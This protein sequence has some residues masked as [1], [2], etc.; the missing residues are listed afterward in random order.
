MS[1][2]AQKTGTITAIRKKNSSVDISAS[3]K[4][5]TRYSVYC[6]TTTEALHMMIPHEHETNTNLKVLK[7]GQEHMLI[8]YLKNYKKCYK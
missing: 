1:T 6:T 3:L 5:N 4:P 8:K 7:I 2:I